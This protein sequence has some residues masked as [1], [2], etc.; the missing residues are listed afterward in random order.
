MI[1]DSVSGCQRKSTL[2]SKIRY[3]YFSIAFEQVI[4]EISIFTPRCLCQRSI[5]FH[6]AACFGLVTSLALSTGRSNQGKQQLDNISLYSFHSFPLSFKLKTKSPP[7]PPCTKIFIFTLHIFFLLPIEKKGSSTC[8]FHSSQYISLH[9][10]P[11]NIPAPAKGDQKTKKKETP[12][13]L[14]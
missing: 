14:K 8:S 3:R 11:Q 7:S 4:C 5:G 9:Q 6:P 13:N 12:Q 1:V 2:A 10:I